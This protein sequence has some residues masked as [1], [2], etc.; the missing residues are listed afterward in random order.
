MKII[1]LNGKRTLLNSKPAL[2]T[3]LLSRILSVLLTVVFLMSALGGLAPVTVQAVEGGYGSNGKFLAPIGEPNLYATPIYTAQELW[4]VRYGL[5]NSYVL[6]NDIDLVDFNSGDWVPIGEWQIEFHG[7]F[8]GQGH[9][10]NNL[11]ITGDE[12]KDNGLFGYIHGGTVIN[13]V[14]P[15]S[16]TFWVFGLPAREI[17]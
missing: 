8:D 10:I 7:A 11:K 1:S 2:E 16:R 13:V 5:S 17:L 14:Y 15:M 4:N 3:N 12:Y 9:V 6:M